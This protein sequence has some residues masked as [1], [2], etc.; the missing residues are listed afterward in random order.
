MH[1][2]IAALVGLVVGGGLGYGFRGKE[3]AALASANSILQIQVAGLKS[4]LAS[5]GK[6]L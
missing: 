4:Q 5:L 3:H 2:L 6:K 1:I